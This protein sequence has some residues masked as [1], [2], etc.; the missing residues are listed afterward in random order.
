MKTT[1]YWAALLIVSGTLFAACNKGF[2]DRAATTQQQDK[3]I[4]TLFS[5][6]D[7][8][9]NNLYSKL[10]EVYGYLQG[11]QM[12]SA[13]D[14][15]KDASNWMASM[16]FNS[17]SL[18][19][20]DNPI[21]NTWRDYYVMIRQANS[22]LEGIEKYN[23]PDNPNRAGDLKNR[24]GE[25]YFLRAWA[26][27]E[28]VRQ[29]GGVI[30]VN[31]VIQDPND[32][33]A[34]KRP[35]NTYDSC[36][37]QIVADCETAYSRVQTATYQPQDFGRVTKA[38][39][40]ALKARILLYSASP[41]WAE[42]GKNTPFPDVSENTF[43]SDPAKWKIA[44]DAAK[45]AIDY[46]TTAGYKLE[47]NLTSRKNMYIQPWNSSEVLWVR[48][49]EEGGS[50]FERHYFPFGYSGWS[51]AAPTQN[52]VDDY[53][54]KDGNPI[55]TS[56]LYKEATPYVDRDPRFYTDILYNGA[57][58]KGRAVETFAGGR[59]EASTNTDH[60][61]TGYYQRKLV[62]EGQ[63]VGQTSRTTD[64]IVFRL[65]ELYLNYAEALN[66]YDPGNADIAQYVNAIRQRA[67]M[68][69]LPDGLNQVQM[70]GRIRNER[71]VELF[72]ENHRFWDVRRW[73]I[74]AQTEQNIWG[75]RAIKEGSGFKYERFL[76]EKRPWRN[77]MLV[78]PV[79]L[80]ETFRNP[81]L[82]QNPGW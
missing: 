58:F 54:M 73:K 37:A 4:F 30:I 3:D 13:T 22:I 56:S 6:T 59:D 11:Y 81:N 75:M 60:S 52:V 46:C 24:I 43:A 12:G 80:D 31:N 82:K 16:R 15:S 40:L 48:M 41:L 77:A 5:Q 65:T 61:R 29:F 55:E 20:T 70:R 1:K 68:P 74:A 45:A 26:L 39:C 64:G 76:V 34:L 44:A 18:S 38:A 25:V 66:E 49:N 42:A 23:T 7:M 57:Q 9:I 71:R 32:D 17:G 8:V 50:E 67:G 21:G 47:P 2:L 53:E 79:T 69:S 14:E 62:D 63:T 19:P 10:P 27:F 51:A 28:L 78:I 33:A 35:R 72:A 36:V